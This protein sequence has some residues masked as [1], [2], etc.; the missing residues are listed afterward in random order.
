MRLTIYFGHKD[1]WKAEP[2]GSMSINLE[3]WLKEKGSVRDFRKILKL[4]QESDRLYE[5]LTVPEL[6][7]FL[8]ASPV[9]IRQKAREIT[10]DYNRRCEDTRQMYDNP[11][12]A[13]EKKREQLKEMKKE[14]RQLKQM[15]D[16]CMKN[17]SAELKQSKKLLGEVEVVCLASA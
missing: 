1:G 6:R 10:K 7:E 3:V 8:E 9:R 11:R 12:I 17:L 15:Y 14:L 13:V 4:C 16:R 5:T 2:R